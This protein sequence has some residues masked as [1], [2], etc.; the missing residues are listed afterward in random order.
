MS[1]LRPR[2]GERI[3]KKVIQFEAGEEKRKTG[4]V[5]RPRN[6]SKNRDT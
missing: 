1:G 2:A 3:R 6:D 5:G 4:K